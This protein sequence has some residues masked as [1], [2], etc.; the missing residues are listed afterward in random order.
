MTDQPRVVV[1]PPSEPLGKSI[2][3]TFSLN[4]PLPA[5]T[6]APISVPA[7]PPGNGPSGSSNSNSKR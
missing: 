1:T 2:F 6:S 5:N 4:V 7:A 3:P